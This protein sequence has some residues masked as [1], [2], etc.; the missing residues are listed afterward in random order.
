MKIITTKRELKTALSFVAKAAKK[1]STMESLTCILIETTE[2]KVELT[3]TDLELTL[4][5]E[6][7]A[8]IVE[9]GKT[10]IPAK[11]LIE[12]VSKLP[13]GEVI[14][15]TSEFNV[16]ITANKFK[17]N[18]FGYDPSDFPKMP[19]YG[20]GETILCDLTALKTKLSQV[21]Y[22]VSQDETKDVLRGVLFNIREN[23]LFIVATDSYRLAKTSL[24]AIHKETLVVSA[25]VP[26]KACDEIAKLT[27]DAVKILIDI[28]TISFVTTNATI[29]SLLISGNYIA[30]EKFIQENKFPT[31]VKINKH[32]LI[33]AT[34]R[35]GLLN[36][37]NVFKLTIGTD[38]VVF[39]TKSESGNS[40]EEV[41]A[42]IT[43]T[44]ITLN[45]NNKFMLEGLKSAM[46]DEIT[47]GFKGNE[48]PCYIIDDAF[49]YVLMPIRA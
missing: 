3:A 27:G 20:K 21:V 1:H 10:L 30:Y 26:K 45:L 24:E 13:D 17:L 48:A 38:C 29:V 4:Q 6:L 31:T 36:D 8:Q 14:I 22:A 40:L 11:K 23:S 5:I 7:P 32:E 49:V 41:S 35:A 33:N 44:N 43:G 39:E 47:W 34:D 37:T 12:T 16:K 46:S 25:I 15:E 2:D 9:Q 19:E 42:V 18:L 28:N